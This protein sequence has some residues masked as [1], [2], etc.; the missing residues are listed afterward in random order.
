MSFISILILAAVPQPSQTAP[1]A[2]G[3]QQ[4]PAQPPTSRA[5]QGKI[6]KFQLFLCLNFSTFINLKKKRQN[7]VNSTSLIKIFIV[8]SLIANIEMMIFDFET[9]SCLNSI[10]SLDICGFL[11]KKCRFQIVSLLKI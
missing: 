3:N 10:F 7:F 11:L 9:F 4:R 5:P 2:W 6:Q 1:S 8:V